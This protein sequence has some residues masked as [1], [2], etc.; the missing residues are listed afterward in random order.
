MKRCGACAE[1]LD[2]S[3]FSKCRS[4]EDGLA[5]R[6]RP[7]DKE[8]G[9]RYA[10]NVRR[11]DATDKACSVCLVVKPPSGFHINRRKPDGLSQR[12]IVCEVAYQ[13]AYRAKN[14]DRL[15]ARKRIE[16]EKNLGA[17]RQSE[18]R[19]ATMAGGEVSKQEWLDTLELF[20]NCC[21]YCLRSDVKVEIDHF[22][23]L[24][25]GGKHTAD[26]LVPACRSCNSSKG[27]RLISV[28]VN[29]MVTR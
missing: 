8:S 15:V 18:C 7:C 23:P 26:N 5:W 19:A 4:T 11:V 12:C 27:N 6:C 21:A 16:H 29:N 22:M 25:R 17:L 14:K 2:D 9:D 24:S 1:E 28:W 20:N 13:A 10:A 3:S